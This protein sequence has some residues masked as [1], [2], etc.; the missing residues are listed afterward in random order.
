LK[1]ISGGWEGQTLDCL[2]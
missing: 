1:N 2:G